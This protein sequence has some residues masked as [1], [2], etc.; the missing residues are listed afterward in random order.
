MIETQHLFAGLIL[1]AGAAAVITLTVFLF[2]RLTASKERRRADEQIARIAQK[3]A[4]PELAFQEETTEP[5]NLSGEG[6]LSDSA[7]FAIEEMLATL[8]SRG[9]LESAENWAENTLRTNPGHLRVAVQLAEI[10]HQRGERK[11]F[12][13]VLSQYV[14]ARRDEL[15]AET[16]GR[17]E[18]MLHDFSRSASSAH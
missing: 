13:D 12:F 8:I 17:L 2:E 7:I 10:H 4:V 16:W 6:P 9:D 11:A 14:I 1:I 5:T 15:G 3:A 18:S